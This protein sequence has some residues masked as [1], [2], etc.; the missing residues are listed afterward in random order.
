MVGLGRHNVGFSIGNT[1]IFVTFVHLPLPR[2]FRPF[3][4]TADNPHRL[5]LSL[6][7]EERISR[8]P[9]LADNQRRKT[10]QNMQNGLRTHK[11]EVIVRFE[12]CSKPFRHF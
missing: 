1:G 9:S 3:T 11:F 5:I 4:R 7:G 2:N 10:K 12:N 8:L 6:K